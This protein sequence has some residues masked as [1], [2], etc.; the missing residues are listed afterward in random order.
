MEELIPAHLFGT[1]NCTADALS[2]L[3]APQCSMVP[4]VCFQGKQ[5]SC[6]VRDGSYYKLPPPITKSQ[7]Q[8]FTVADEEVKFA[9][10]SCPWSTRWPLSSNSCWSGLMSLTPSLLGAVSGPLPPP[11][12]FVRLLFFFVVCLC[13]RGFGA[14]GLLGSSLSWAVCSLS[15]FC[16][17]PGRRPNLP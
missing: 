9:T 15:V 1:V 4:A 8:L 11:S 14:S 16:P 10:F 17:G 13:P 5:R 6:P 12:F 3:A 7:D 2:R